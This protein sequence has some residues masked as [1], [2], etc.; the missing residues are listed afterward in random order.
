[1][2]LK[3]DNSDNTRKVDKQFGLT[4]LSLKNNVVIYFLTFII[5]VMGIIT[6]QNLP[7]DSYPEIKQPTIYV[8]VLYPGNSPVDME[9]LVTRPI[10]KEINAIS[11]VDHIKSSAV[12]DYTTIIVEFNPETAV[13]DALTKVKDAVDKAKPELP[14]DAEDRH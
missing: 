5:V 13:E 4:T 3:N 11:E 2:S 7:K 8:G 14:A 6:Y 12:Q 1:M 9:N 10:E